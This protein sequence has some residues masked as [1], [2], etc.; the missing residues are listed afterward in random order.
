[1]KKQVMP[2]GTEL[3][4]S[5]YYIRVHLDALRFWELKSFGKTI[6]VYFIG[7]R[8][9]WNG[10]CSWSEDGPDWRPKEKIKVMLVVKNNWTKPFYI[11]IP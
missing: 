7:Y 10:S 2:I 9:L 3:T 6:N 1:M 8:T 5:C 11:P 4:A